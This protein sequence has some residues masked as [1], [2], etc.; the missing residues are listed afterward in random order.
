MK[1]FAILQS[2]LDKEQRDYLN[3]ILGITSRPQDT[4]FYVLVGTDLRFVSIH[5][6]Y[7][8]TEI[9]TLLTNGDFFIHL[10]RNCNMENLLWT[11]N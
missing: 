9:F 4:H 7:I 2:S 10:Y 5:T 6:N 3:K 8:S 11:Q 1:S